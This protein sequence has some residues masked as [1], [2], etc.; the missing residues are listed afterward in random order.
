VLAL[1]ALSA[2]NA[3]QALTG[4]PPAPASLA[5]APSV[6]ETAAHIRA[7]MPALDRAYCAAAAGGR[8]AELID[9]GD[10]LRRLGHVA[11]DPEAFGA[12]ALEIYRSALIHARRQA[13]LDGV[14][15]VAEGLGELGDLDGLKECVRIA[16]LLAA[17]DREADV[18]ALTTRFANE[19][20]RAGGPG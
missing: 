4:H 16:A 7:A 9:L 20:E 13:S 5:Q 10:V 1:V 11:G 12:A 15:R 6:N 18:R 3:G 8:W 14:L 2:G 17:G 19:L